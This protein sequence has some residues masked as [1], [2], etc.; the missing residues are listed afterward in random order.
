MITVI[1][2]VSGKVIEQIS[3][4]RQGEVKE[5]GNDYLIE[6]VEPSLTVRHRYSDGA[7][8]LAQKLLDLLNSLK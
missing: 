3:A 7:I 5:D 2:E 8:V 6:G 4:T 1:V